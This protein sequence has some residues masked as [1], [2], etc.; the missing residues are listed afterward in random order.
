MFKITHGKVKYNHTI[1]GENEEA[2]DIITGLSTEQEESLAKKGYGEILKSKAKKA[3]K[4]EGHP[5]PDIS[6]MNVGEVQKLIEATED[7]ELLKK[8]HEIEMANK[9][10]KTVLEPLKEKLEELEAVEEGQGVNVDINIDD[11]IVDSEE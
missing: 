1:Y 9:N 10:R 2:G 7:V 6:E 5:L 3:E 11:V 4:K 8:L